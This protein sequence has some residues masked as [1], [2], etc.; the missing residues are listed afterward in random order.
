MISVLQPLERRETLG[1]AL[2]AA[3]E[4]ARA[5]SASLGSFRAGAHG[6]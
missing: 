4:I 3:C 6:K 2:T 1:I 5:E